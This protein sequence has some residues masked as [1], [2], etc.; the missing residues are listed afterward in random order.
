MEAIAEDQRSATV[1]GEVDAARWKGIRLKRLPRGASLGV[2]LEVDGTVELL[3]LEER[4]FRR[5]PEHQSP[6]FSSRVVERMGV[7]MKIPASGDY[8]LILDN[9]AGDDKRA[10]TITISA[11]PPGG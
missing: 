4:A 9:R 1:S 6:A 10:F 3:L 5:F 2:E 7:S 8:Y 11:A